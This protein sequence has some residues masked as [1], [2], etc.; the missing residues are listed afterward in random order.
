MDDLIFNLLKIIVACC[1]IL[2]TSYL[3]PFIKTK[4][5]EAKYAQ[6]LDMV[7]KAVWA[8][9]Q[10]IKGSGMGKERK[11]EVT[12]IVLEWMND[13]GI[14]ISLEQLNQ[15]IEAAVFDMNGQETY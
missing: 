14:K 10:T 12:R 1:S 7:E 15:L 4:L 11:A 3:V 9:E 2:I 8:A 5:Q 13:N 6:L